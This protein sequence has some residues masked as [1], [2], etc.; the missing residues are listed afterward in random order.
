MIPLR[1]DNPS[2][3]KPVVTV[4]LLAV[5]ALVFCWQFSVGPSAEE[6]VVY[7]LGLIPR[8][9]FGQHELPERLAIMP[10]A[11][12]VLTSM[13]LHDGWLADSGGGVAFRA[14]VGGFVAGMALVAVFK[15]PGVR[16]FNPLRA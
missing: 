14:H 5:V 11:A 15:R 10:P 3:A 6:A 1:D 4:A 9:L 16:L 8:A 13:F 7:A 2:A 12:T